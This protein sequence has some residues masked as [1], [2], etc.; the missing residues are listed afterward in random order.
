M[1]VAAWPLQDSVVSQELLFNLFDHLYLSEGVLHVD[2]LAVSAQESGV[3]V[4]IAPGGCIVSYDS[5]YGGKRVFFSTDEERSGTERITNPSYAANVLNWDK[6]GPIAFVRDTVV[7]NSSPASGKITTVGAAIYNQG[8][9]P[10]K[11]Y[12]AGA[13]EFQ[14]LSCWFRAP[15]GTTVKLRMMEIHTPFYSLPNPDF[16]INTSGWAALGSAIT[17]DTGN[18]HSGAAGL[19]IDTTGSAIF[20]GVQI[21]NASCPAASV[22]Q[23]W[24]ASCWVKGAGQVV[25]VIQA[26]DSSNNI[27]NG[28]SSETISLT[29]T[30]HALQVFSNPLPPGTAKVK[31]L[32]VGPVTQDVIFYTD[33]FLLFDI[34]AN[35]EVEAPGTGVWNKIIIPQWA[36]KND[37]AF[38]LPQLM[39]HSPSTVNVNVDDW[40][41]RGSFHWSQGM[42]QSDPALPRVDRIVVEIH[43]ESMGG[44][45]TATD[46]KFRAIS[47]VPTSGAN[48]T[49]LTGAAAVPNNC[50]LLANVVVPAGAAGLADVNINTAVREIVELNVPKIDR[51]SMAEFPPASADDAQRITLIISNDVE[52]I[53]IYDEATNY[54]KFLGGSPLAVAIAGSASRTAA[55]Y[56]DLTGS[57]GPS[58][59][60]PF[61]GDYYAEI[62][63]RAQP[64]GNISS[65]MAFSWNGDTNYDPRE[66]IGYASVGAVNGHSKTVM[67]GLATGDVLASKYLSSVSIGSTFSNRMISL[68]PIRL[69]GS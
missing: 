49:N 55:T 37:A 48:L 18:A 20:E 57:P 24:T 7:F 62:Q 41:M 17:R 31:L 6:V 21:P 53:L 30:W 67:P 45:D 47:G 3:G 64:S 26:L 12:K 39:V 25:L 46:A 50:F 28:W 58:V 68:T 23:I 38:L 1:S 35:N 8:I 15:I 63:F 34:S 32:V 22:G 14:E 27:L 56:G 36:L 40:D 33:D 69:A 2:D 11:L 42:E 52:W 51:L 29:T 5:V 66:A 16:E 9:Q 60:V 65:Q 54:W 59:T 61:A 19:K 4:K 43:D 44:G 10:E 13:G